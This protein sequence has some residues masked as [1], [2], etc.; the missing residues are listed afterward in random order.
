[1]H[2]DNSIKEQKS[3]CLLSRS[4]SKRSAHLSISWQ[5][6]NEAESL[7]KRTQQNK[8]KE[9]KKA[10]SVIFALYLF[11]FFIEITSKQTLCDWLLSF[12]HIQF[13]DMCSLSFYKAIQSACAQLCTSL[14]R[15]QTDDSLLLF[16]F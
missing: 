8:M 4:C 15:R 13:G 11:I 12:H 1:M 10:S 16:Y 14:C 3:V 6:L 9:R 7:N 5:R 2:V